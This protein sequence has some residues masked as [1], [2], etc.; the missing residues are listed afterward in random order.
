MREAKGKAE[1]T[2]LLDAYRRWQKSTD[3]EL[4]HVYGKASSAKHDAMRRCRQLM[5]DLNGRGL[6]IISHNCDTFTVGFEYPDEETGELNFAFITK[7]YDRFIR[8]GGEKA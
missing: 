4:H 8:L 6:K 3:T 7:A 5:Y 1:T 2:L